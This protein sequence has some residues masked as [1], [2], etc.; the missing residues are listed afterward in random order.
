MYKVLLKKKTER[1]ALRMPKAEQ[2]VLIDLLKDLRDY[3]PVLPDWK[4]FSMLS[5]NEC[6]YHCHLSYHWVACWQVTV[7]G[8]E[9]EVY[10][11]GS[12]E[13]APY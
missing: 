7:K 2:M 3:G 8:I 1:S 13:N 10:Y 6:K 4:N 9:I 5:R 12:R 11:V